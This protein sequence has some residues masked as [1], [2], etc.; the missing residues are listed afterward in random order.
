MGKGIEGNKKE[1]KKFYHFVDINKM[2]GNRFSGILAR[3]GCFFV[4]SART[5]SSSTPLHNRFRY[6]G[7]WYISVR[8]QQPLMK[9][10]K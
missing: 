1:L 9:E 5:G 3:L 2:I 6:T 4:K 10:R 8:C 7:V